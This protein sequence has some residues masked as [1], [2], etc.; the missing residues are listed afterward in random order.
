[1]S[2]TTGR[3]QLGVEA[4]FLIDAGVV[5]G[6]ANEAILKPQGANTAAEASECCHRQGTQAAGGVK[7]FS[8]HRPIDS[9]SSSANN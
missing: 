8:T 9:C 2:A 5:A 1:M 7:H 3:E 6:A 4:S